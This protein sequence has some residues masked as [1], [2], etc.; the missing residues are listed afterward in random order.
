M[1]ISA[2]EQFMIELVNR[3]RLDPAGE[4]ELL[5]VALNK[6]VSAQRISAQSYQPLAVNQSLS[7]SS[8]AHSRW[9]LRNE[10]VSHRGDAGSNAG[11]RIGS[12]G[13]DLGRN[14]TWSENVAFRASSGTLNKT[15]AI[16]EQHISLFE[17]PLHRLNMFK[18]TVAE[19]GV[20][21]AVGN[22]M[23]YQ[24][25]LVTQ[26]FAARNKSVFLTG[27]A[28]T[29][30]NGD[31]FYS[32]G[33]GKRGVV[34]SVADQQSRSLAAGGY[35]VEISP[36]WGTKSVSIRQG[37][38]TMELDVRFRGENV[39]LDVVG[40]RDIEVSASA[41]LIR[42]VAQAELLGVKNLSLTGNANDNVLIGNSGN[43]I[44]RG[45]G[46]DDT[47]R[48]G[49]GRDRLFGGKGSDWVDYRDSDAGVW[50]HLGRGQG[51]FGDANGDR[52][53]SIENVLG[54][55]AGD[56]ITGN[57]KSNR[58]LGGAGD[59]TLDGGNG[60]D[61][62]MGGDGDD[63]L[64]GSQ[65]ADVMNGGSGFDR[66]DYSRSMQAVAVDLA[67]AQPQR[68]G[69]AHGDVLISIEAVTGSRFNDSLSG[70]V[71]ANT[72]NGGAGNDTI[73]GR[74]GNDLLTGGAG[75]DVFVFRDNW[76]VD[77]I[78]DF[79][80]SVDQIRIE[81]AAL[82]GAALEDL[83]TQQG[84]TVLLDA[85]SNGRIILQGGLSVDA[86]IAAIDLF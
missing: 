75:A 3:A 74:G 12:A 54:S 24:A 32:I 28:Y 61:R 56:W 31:D 83:I 67:S 76:G 37:Q 82:G 85:G 36:T 6:G 11:D 70:D 35:A 69:H 9:M 77:T 46:G 13:Y 84:S 51:R 10:T 59:D 50:V 53:F 4:A 1:A 80:P 29:D 30:R 42:G 25:S 45:G 55:A 47:L 71:G 66:V 18:T 8:D 68:G 58:L 33:E 63:L 78:T 43:N 5:G 19:I 64:L 44:L 40:A 57:A 81:R 62:I 23:G 34:F 2:Q 7:Q 26:N 22:F 79:T 15:A 38:K 65:G 14:A 60:L 39:K 52:L 21:Q 72:L 49:E 41:K 48:G 16:I 27:V 86:V 73:E 20:G 17:S